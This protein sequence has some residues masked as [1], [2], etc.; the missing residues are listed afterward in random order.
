MQL[1]K[2]EGKKKTRT[3][4]IGAGWIACMM[5][6]NKK[7][8]SI[9]PLKPWAIILTLDMPTAT[10][11]NFKIPIIGGIFGLFLI[12]QWIK[13]NKMMVSN[14]YNQCKRNIIFHI[15]HNFVLVYMANMSNLD[16][17]N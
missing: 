12:N 14:Y 11:I 2:K 9:G 6:K 10:K 4:K 7:Y 15:N 1:R 8:I 5:L 3:H 16:L 17:S 13:P